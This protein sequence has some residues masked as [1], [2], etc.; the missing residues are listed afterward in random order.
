VALPQSLLG[1][2]QDLAG[3]DAVGRP[4]QAG[5]RRAVSTAYYALFQLLVGAAVRRLFQNERDRRLYGAML[6]RLFTHTAVKSVCQDARKAPGQRRKET[7]AVL[8]SSRAVGGDLLTVCTAFVALHEAREHA[9]YS[10]DWRLQRSDVQ[11]LLRQA[12]AAFQAW[13]RIRAT[14]EGQAFAMLLALSGRGGTTR[15]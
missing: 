13:E 9:D 4:R 10:P 7:N 6:V 11:A 15:S 12:G 3:L 2:A 1:I 5:L 14:D 8:G